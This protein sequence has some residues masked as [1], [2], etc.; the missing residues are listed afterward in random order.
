LKKIGGNFL[1]KIPAKIIRLFKALLMAGILLIGVFGGWIIALF[2]LI[3]I[4]FKTIYISIAGKIP[5]KTDKKKYIG[6][7][8]HT[9][10]TV[11]NKKLKM[12]IYYPS[13][14]CNKYPVIIFTHGGG[15][16]T[17]SRRQANDM[18]WCEYLT[19]QGFAVA[20]MDYR[21]GYLNYIEDILVDYDNGYKYIVNNA[22]ELK[23]DE[24]RIILMGLSAGAHLSLFYGIYNT[25]KYKEKFK[26]IKGIVSWYCPCDLV[27]LYDND[28]ESLFARFAIRT[29]MKGGL[30]KKKDEYTHFSPINWVSKNNPPVFLVHGKM[31]TTVPYKSS[32]K[33][34]KKLKENN[35]NSKL[36]IH[37]KGNHGFEF[38]LKDQITIKI[39]QE[40]VYFIKNRFK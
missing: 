16:I 1:K 6:P 4:N 2:V 5:L 25:S 33:M 26:N 9:Y 7:Y 17:G 39:I 21:F 31:D 12:D 13:K 19:S 24:K 27:D 3:I 20:S 28:V 11:K 38:E 29:T 14:E 23:I 37:P 36:K 34:Y 40:N 30:D 35:V 22:R 15:W 18:S 10:E 32:I 8:T